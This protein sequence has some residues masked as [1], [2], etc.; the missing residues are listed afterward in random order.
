[1]ILAL[2][3]IGS[4]VAILWLVGQLG[5]AREELRHVAHERDVYAKELETLIV[6]LAEEEQQS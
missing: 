5:E 4:I 3:V 1:M 6:E 2:Y